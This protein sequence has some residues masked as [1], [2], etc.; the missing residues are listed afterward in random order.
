MV[1]VQDPKVARRA[2]L[3]RNQGMEK[4]Y[5]NEIPG[6]NFRMTDV[7]AA[8]GIQQLKKL[9]Y[10]NSKRQFNAHT[11]LEELNSVNL[12]FTPSGFEHVYHQFTIS[13]PSLRDQLAIKLTQSNIGNSV[14]YPTQVH[15]LPSF[16]RDLFL[17]RTLEATQSVLS[18]PVHPRLNIRDIKRVASRINEIMESL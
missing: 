16:S 11:Y 2:K 15:K 18:I 9:E 3:L 5:E 12:P 7:H 4:R 1:V 14:Y 8:I 13:V 10:W 17:P 6:F